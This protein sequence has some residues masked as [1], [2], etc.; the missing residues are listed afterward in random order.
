MKNK[1]SIFLLIFIFFSLFSICSEPFRVN[2]MK[3][4]TISDSDATEKATLGIND[5][6]AIQLPQNKQFLQGIELDI[7]IPK[8]VAAY[9]DSIVY[10]IYTNVQP[11]PNEDII[12]Y[13]GKK[14]FLD[15]LPGRLSYSIQISLDNNNPLKTS[16]YSTLLP[17]TIEKDTNTLIL[18]LQLAMKGVPESFFT[19]MFDITVKPI[20]KNE[21]LF[22]LNLNYPKVEEQ[23][24]PV[25]VYI[26]EKPVSSFENIVLPTGTHHISIISENYR[27]EMR[28]FSILQAKETI[29]DVDLKP[30]TPEI[31]I[32][33]P[34]TSEIYLDNELIEKTSNP[35]SVEPGEH[36][37]KF[38]IGDYEVSKSVQVINGKTYTVNL[39]VNIDISE[40]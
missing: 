1:K 33:A 15:T 21:G 36:T 2:E 26:D 17:I 16:P 38:V 13:I 22:T 35:I 34:E 39:S 19:A 10:Y 25:L 11:T 3:I 4:V 18:R 40:E 9:R 30:T 8:D 5:S 24:S 28:T 32:S 14:L 29:L 6:L 27:N 23:N 7:K 12:D 37:I 31:I 20:L